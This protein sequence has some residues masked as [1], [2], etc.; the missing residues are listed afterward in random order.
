MRPI[1]VRS[2]LAGGFRLPRLRHGQSLATSN[3]GMDLGMCPLRQADLGDRRHDQAPLEAAADPVVLGRLSDGHPFQRYLGT[4]TTTPAWPR[5][6]QI[7]LAVVGQTAT[8][9]G[10]QRPSPLAGLVEVD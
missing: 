5:L 8:Q 2:A 6:L 7:S 9:H 1:S 10:G 3:E 4:A